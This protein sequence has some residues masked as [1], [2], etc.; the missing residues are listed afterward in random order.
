MGWAFNSVKGYL[1]FFAKAIV[2]QPPQVVTF[3]TLLMLWVGK[4]KKR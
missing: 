2:D 1:L 3:L 4:S